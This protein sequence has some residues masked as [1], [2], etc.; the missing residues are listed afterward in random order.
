[1]LKGKSWLDYRNLY[2]PDDYEKNNKIIL[3]FKITKKKKQLYC[4]ICGKCKKF[5]K[6]QNIISLEKNISSLYYLK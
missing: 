4:V 3:I 2:S 6:T 1:M 5:E